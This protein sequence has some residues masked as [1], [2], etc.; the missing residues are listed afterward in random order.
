[1][2]N[3]LA[4]GIAVLILLVPRQFVEA[5]PITYDFTGSTGYPSGNF[6]GSL[7]F[8]TNPTVASGATSIVENGGDVSLTV[9]FGGGNV[10]N[11]VNN[12]QN[13]Y[14]TA[15]FAVF[16]VPVIN[17]EPLG[18]PTYEIAVSGWSNNTA[19]FAM[20]FYTSP[21]WVEHLSSLDGLDLTVDNDSVDANG[22]DGKLTSIEEVSAPEP[23]MLAVFTVLSVAVWIKGSCR[24]S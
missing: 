3:R 1:M 12:P 4:L 15:S 17:E 9:N 14:V 10:V 7:T 5:S 2:L 21:G 11:F 6:S 18:V 8:D 22:V 20:M 19:T 24:R 13:P 23:R 16:D